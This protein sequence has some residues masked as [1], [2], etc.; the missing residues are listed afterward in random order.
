MTC[1]HY[2]KIVQKIIISDGSAMA[3][4][5]PIT[6][7]DDGV[8]TPANVTCCQNPA[9]TVSDVEVDLETPNQVD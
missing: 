1:P 8:N 6:D 9:K 4:K 7:N 2:E 5:R 3:H